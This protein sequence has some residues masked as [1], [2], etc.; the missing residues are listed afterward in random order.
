MLLT[1]DIGNTN[2]TIG[3]F[4]NPAKDELS[5]TARM[6]TAHGRTAD[7][8]AADL[9]NVIA[10]SFD[11][12]DE[13]DSA[14]IS[15]VV[16][17]M[18]DVFRLAIKRLFGV[19]SMVLGPGVKTGL[20]ILIDNPAQLG[21]DIVAV[22][23]AAKELFPLPNAVC[24]LGTAST[25]SVLDRHGNM[26]GVIIYP[27]IHTSLDALVQDTSLLQMIS[28]D[29]PARV[30]GRNTVES[31]QSGVI[32]GAAILLDGMMER[33]EDELGEPVTAIATG[34]LSASVTDHSKR[35]FI[36]SENLVLIG[37]RRIYNK[38]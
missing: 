37:L 33:I 14:I 10:L 6:T 18:T 19:D 8:Y 2:I 35:D 17:P 25:I 29:A 12:F 34:G 24:D 27:G 26:L 31:M 30:I 7:E 21:A 5:F 16:P 23:V 20:N 36:I 22:S 3:G 32:F 11:H 15:S 9:R 4:K 13:I 28:L 38:N 1:V